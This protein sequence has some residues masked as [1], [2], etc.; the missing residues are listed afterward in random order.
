M[1]STDTNDSQH[2]HHCFRNQ[3]HINDHPIALFHA[4]FLQSG[5]Q[6]RN[7]QKLFILI[8]FYFVINETYR[9]YRIVQLL[10]RDF[11][12]GAGQW[13]IVYDGYFAAVSG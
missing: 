8:D 10:I 13:A 1:H 6:Q 12:N 4:Q 5:C 2:C 7:L 9:T 3:W 11:S